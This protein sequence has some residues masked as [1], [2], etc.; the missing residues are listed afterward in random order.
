M[1]K[2]LLFPGLKRT[3]GL[4]SVEVQMDRCTFPF[5]A[6]CCGFGGDPG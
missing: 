1:K 3:D 4:C 5:A 2:A 6:G